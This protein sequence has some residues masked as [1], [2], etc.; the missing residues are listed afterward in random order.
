MESRWKASPNGAEDLTAGNKKGVILITY[1]AVWAELSFQFCT[2]CS[3]SI[4]LYN[5]KKKFSV[6]FK[7]S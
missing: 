3:K 1:A 4:K 2:N 7:A 6:T 5:P